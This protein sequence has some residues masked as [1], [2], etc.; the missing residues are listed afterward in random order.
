MIV[1][2]TKFFK[3]W[4]FVQKEIFPGKKLSLPIESRQTGKLYQR[5]NQNRLGPI[6]LTDFILSGF[7]TAKSFLDQA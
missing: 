2:L 6:G 5:F 3:D 1:K 4:F 7:L